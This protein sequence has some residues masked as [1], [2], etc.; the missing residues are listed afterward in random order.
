MDRPSR[1]V[2]VAIVGATAISGTANAAYVASLSYIQPT[3]TVLTT[4]AIDV[5]LRLTLDPSSDPLNLVGDPV[6][7]PPFGVPL[8]NYPTNTDFEVYDPNTNTTTSHSGGTIVSLQQVYLNTFFEC[9][10]TFV[11][12]CNGNPYTFNFNTT[13]PESINFRPAI[14]PGD[15]N[16]A[17]GGSL[18]YLFG[19]FTPDGGAAP[20]G[21]YIFYRTG[22]TL[23][24]YGVFQATEQV[25]DQNGDPIPLL[26]QNGDPVLD[27]FG[28]PVYQ[29]QVNTY[30]NANASVDLA[31]TQCGNQGVGC[32]GTN[33]AFV[34]DV[35]PVPA[36]GWLLVSALGAVGFARRRG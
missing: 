7:P 2:I 32:D 19:T 24:F 20:V 12:G 25:L 15:I 17:P 18:D 21:S 10:G 8:A 31:V 3:G 13:G 1:L 22:V 29:T 11:T 23:N 30:D 14:T 4:D 28:N 27:P 16:V 5:R 6:G 36:A 35:V 9:S 26:D 34:R 33:G